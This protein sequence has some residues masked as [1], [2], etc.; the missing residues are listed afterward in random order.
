M[1]DAP[2]RIWAV[3]SLGL[4][5]TGRWVTQGLENPHNNVCYIRADL[6]KADKEATLREGY[7]LG[8]M[9]SA[10]GFNGE[11]PFEGVDPTTNDNWLRYRD[12]AI[13]KS[14]AVDPA[15]VARI[16]EGGE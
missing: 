1:T 10:E 13:S 4:V 5:G 8:F 15:A 3:A 16:V 6:A 11:Y 9:E 2:E 7:L 14:L 12:R